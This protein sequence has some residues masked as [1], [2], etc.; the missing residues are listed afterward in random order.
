MSPSSFSHYFLFLWQIQMFQSFH[1][2]FTRLILIHHWQSSQFKLER[3]LLQGRISLM[4]IQTRCP[5]IEHYK[6]IRTLGEGSFARVKRKETFAFSFPRTIKRKIS[7]QTRVH[8]E[9][10]R[11][12]DYLQG[13]DHQNSQNENKS[14]KK[15]FLRIL[16]AS[17]NLTFCFKADQKRNKA[18]PLLQPPQPDKTL[19]NTGVRP[20]H[21]RHYGVRQW[22]GSLRTGQ[23]TRETGWV[24]GLL[25]FHPNRLS[26]GILPLESG[27]SSR[28]EARE[29]SR[30][31]GRKDQTGWLWLGEL[32]EGREVP[33][34][35][36]WISELRGTWVNFWEVCPL[37]D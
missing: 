27:D 24:S 1:L 9:Q 2:K 35:A 28:P 20:Q 8:W 22:R 19:P 23:K 16:K 15:P 11:H 31:E 36:L 7:W 18:A 4:D 3:F 6:I 12:Q 29:H 14:M 33:E 17:K 21:L 30:E 32:L 26:L 10:G 25:F 37:V 34:D 5:K 13:K